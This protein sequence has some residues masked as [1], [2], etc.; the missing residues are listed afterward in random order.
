MRH[1]AAISKGSSGGAWRRHRTFNESASCSTKVSKD[2]FADISNVQI[3]PLFAPPESTPYWLYAHQGRQ[4]GCG[5]P[6]VSDGSSQPEV[7]AQP[8]QLVFITI[9]DRPESAKATYSHVVRS[10]AMQSFLCEKREE[11]KPSPKK[12]KTASSTAAP[13]TAKIFHTKFKLSTWSRKSSKNNKAFSA[14]DE[15]GTRISKETEIKF[16]V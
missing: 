9:T 15:S 5:G 13:V 11:L 3:N 6:G 7:V 4:E 14:L 8:R 16:Q 1:A 12:T 2:T 10:Q